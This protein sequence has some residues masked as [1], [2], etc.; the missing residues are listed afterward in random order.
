MHH[1]SK[2][3]RTSECQREYASG[4]L[5]SGARADDSSD[6][7]PR[8]VER[9]RDVAEQLL[10]AARRGEQDLRRQIAAA[11][12]RAM[13]L[14][15]RIVR[16]R[17]AREPLGSLL[18]GADHRRPPHAETAHPAISDTGAPLAPA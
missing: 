16:A 4:G 11:F 17:P 6:E 18:H 14:V 9:G 7:M 10:L 2:L 5:A 1:L 3:L 13:N 8:A 15:D 12:A